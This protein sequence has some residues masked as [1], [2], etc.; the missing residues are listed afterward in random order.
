MSD[1]APDSRDPR[2]DSEMVGRAG[3]FLDHNCLRRRNGERPCALRA[4]QSAKLR[5]A[6]RKERLRTCVPDAGLV[7][8][9]KP[10]IRAPGVGL[11]W[12]AGIADQA[13]FRVSFGDNLRQRKPSIG[14]GR[15]NLKC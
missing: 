12:K 3:I 11:G 4:R 10:L 14:Q 8:E 6:A 1:Q 5:L 13:V 9:I 2:P 15:G 7:V